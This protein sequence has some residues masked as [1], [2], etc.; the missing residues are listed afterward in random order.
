MNPPPITLGLTL[1]EK[2]ITEERTRNLTLVSTFRTL[3]VD[4]FPT[5]PQRLA[6][7]TVLTAGQGDAT[8]DLA[9]THLATDEE[10]YSIRRQLRF[11]NRLEEVRVAFHI[12]DCSFPAPG[13][14]EATLFVD[15]DP[16]ARRKF[17]VRDREQ[18]P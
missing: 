12:R 13:H 14:Y 2:V 5:L 17:L 7:A 10:I 18:E 8:I 6:F 3:F 4:D 1:C 16:V 11:P 9:I 15:G